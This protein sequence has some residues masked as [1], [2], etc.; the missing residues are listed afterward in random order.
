MAWRW[1][2]ELAGM[3]LKER[4]IIG[5]AVFELVVGHVRVHSCR[6]VRLT[7]QTK[8]SF[9]EKYLL[10]KGIE[11][12]F[13]GEGLAN[14]DDAFTG[15]ACRDDLWGR[16]QGIKVQLLEQTGLKVHQGGSDG[17]SCTHHQLCHFLLG[18][19][20]GKEEL[21]S[22]DWADEQAVLVVLRG[23]ARSP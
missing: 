21:M 6:E 13:P 4:F 15:K 7:I 1:R 20:G 3:G 22:R 11:T 9:S 12:C 10:Q 2:R 23:E 8:I 14:S 17:V 19:E 18:D 16:H 5:R